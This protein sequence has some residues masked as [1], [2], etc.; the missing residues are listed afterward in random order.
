MAGR[1]SKLEQETIINF[2]EAEKEASVYTF[3]PALKRKLIDLAE[4][5]P[6]EVK[7]AGT[8]FSEDA[9][10]YLVPKSWIRLYPPRETRELTEEQKEAARAR[11]AKIHEARR[12]KQAII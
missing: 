1:R 12:K 6:D 5:R 9:V 8:L 2:N 10:E 11:I 3:N 7:P 4:K